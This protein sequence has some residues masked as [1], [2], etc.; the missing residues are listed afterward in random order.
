MGA[1]HRPLN[2]AR[3]ALRSAAMA[4]SSFVV[5]PRHHVSSN[6]PTA[7]SG[8]KPAWNSRAAV[9]RKVSSRGSKHQKRL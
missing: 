6:R 1:V 7:Q 9:T 5:R 8:G 4:G 3:A 2:V